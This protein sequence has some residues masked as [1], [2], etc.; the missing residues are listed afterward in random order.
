MSLKVF[1]RRYAKGKTDFK[2]LEADYLKSNSVELL[3]PRN[4]KYFSALIINLN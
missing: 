2:A 3:L 1:T 4:P